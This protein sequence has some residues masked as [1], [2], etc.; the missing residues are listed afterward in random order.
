MYNTGDTLNNIAIYVLSVHSRHNTMHVSKLVPCHSQSPFII[1]DNFYNDSLIAE[2]LPILKGD[3]SFTIFCC[4]DNLYDAINY[5][6]SVYTLTTQKQLS[7]S[8]ASAN[9]ATE[10]LIAHAVVDVNNR[11][12]K[13][14][15]KCLHNALNTTPQL[16]ILNKFLK[17]L[18][19]RLYLYVNK[20]Y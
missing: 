15:I 1:S 6:C 20:T 3:I 7:Y 10:K 13:A 9:D 11:L 12:F 2:P 18:A 8:V 19:W 4:E 14:N 17:K 16:T 5:V